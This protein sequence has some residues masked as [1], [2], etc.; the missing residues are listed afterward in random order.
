MKPVK[1]IFW[2]V[3]LLGLW[4]STILGLH[5]WKQRLALDEPDLVGLFAANLP[6]DTSPDSESRVEKVIGKDS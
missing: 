5:F 6:P 1:P 3:G 4:Y 2:A